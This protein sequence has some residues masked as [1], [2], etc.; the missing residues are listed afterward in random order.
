MTGSTM[1]A[2]GSADLPERLVSEPLAI[3]RCVYDGVV[4]GAD[5]FVPPN[6]YDYAW[7]GNRVGIGCSRLI[8]KR[9]GQMVSSW[10]GGVPSKPWSLAETAEIATH[11]DLQAFIERRLVVA[12][13]D[14]RTYACACFSHGEFYGR[15]MTEGEEAWEMATRPPWRCAGHPVLVPPEALDDLEIDDSLD[16]DLLVETEL[17]TPVDHG[18]WRGAWL[19]RLWNVLRPSPIAD[20]IDA[21]VAVRLTDARPRVRLLAIDF[22]DRNPRADG[23]AT[24]LHLLRTQPALFKGVPN[25]TPAGGDLWKWALQALAGRVVTVGDA[26]ALAFAEA[27]VAAGDVPGVLRLALADPDDPRVA[28]I[29][30]R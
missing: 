20:R 9:C 29:Y 22:F 8:C 1:T 10:T 30:G 28:D 21:A 13:K 11:A 14:G 26:E 16:V 4:V 5:R 17:S 23:A 12:Q 7:P 27:C 3:H 25:P 24:L 2:T 6:A 15:G 18:P 19:S